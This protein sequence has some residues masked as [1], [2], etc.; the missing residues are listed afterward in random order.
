MSK[1]A[2]AMCW[3]DEA[4]WNLLKELDPLALDDTYEIWR[5]NATRALHE[6]SQAGHNI[7]KVSVKIE[8]FL[9]WC[10]QKGVEPN[11]ESRSAYAVWKLQHRDRQS[12]AMP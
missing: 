11:A 2:L 5:T 9:Q 12:A 1:S 6:M 10:D 3:Y 4:Q 8:A 7:K